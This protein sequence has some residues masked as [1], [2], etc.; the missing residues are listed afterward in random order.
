MQDLQNK[1]LEDFTPFEEEQI[2]TKTQFTAR[3]KEKLEHKKQ[4]NLI[5]AKNSQS[6]QRFFTHRSKQKEDFNIES[7]KT[8]SNTPLTTKR[9]LG[10]GFHTALSERLN[11]IHLVSQNWYQLL[12]LLF[13][14][15]SHQVNLKF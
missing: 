14:F 5:R 3:F 11:K 8:I 9:N 1:A 6:T 7:M 15:R 2:F 4:W 13:F 10:G 12:S